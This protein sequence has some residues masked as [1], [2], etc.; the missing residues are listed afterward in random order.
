M[1]RP[2][3]LGAVGSRPCI[4]AGDGVGKN[5]DKV[6]FSECGSILSLLRKDTA[7]WQYFVKAQLHSWVRQ[8][9][10]TWNFTAVC[11]NGMHKSNFIPKLM[12]GFGLCGSYW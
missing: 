9:L 5:V 3:S 1:Q 12:E 10:Q 11:T 7:T 2:F 8:T 6:W 4:A